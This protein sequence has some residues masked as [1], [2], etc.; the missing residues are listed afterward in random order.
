MLKPGDVVL[1][2]GGA[3]LDPT[4]YYEHP[5]Y[6]RML[7]A[8]LFSD[9]RQPGDTMPVKVLRDGERLDLQLPLRAMRPEQDRVPPYVFGRGPDY[10][11]VGGLVF[12]ELT[13]PYLGA[14]GDWAR[15]AP[16][17]LLVAIDREPDEAGT[18]PQRIVLLSSV[19]PDA[20]NL[21]YQELR[22]LIVERVNGRPVASLADVRR[23][24]AAPEGGFQVVDF[25]AGP[26]VHPRGPGRRGSPGRRRTPPPGLRGREARL[27]RALIPPY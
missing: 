24:L 14:W 3:K 17:R 22:D 18:E 27:R 21:G 13:R 15:R 6:G 11:V 9:G 5:L 12:E 16:P 10:V 4:G 20:A 7:F 2:M 23:A 8:L 19:L 1:E 25:V 26:G